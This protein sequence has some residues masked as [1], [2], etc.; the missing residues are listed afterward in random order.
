MQLRTKSIHKIAQIEILDRLGYLFRNEVNRQ[1]VGARIEN[2]ES[3]G[4]VDGVVKRSKP[5]NERHCEYV[6]LRGGPVVR[7]VEVD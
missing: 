2:S 4:Q 7:Q 1:N 6:G 5:A 3:E